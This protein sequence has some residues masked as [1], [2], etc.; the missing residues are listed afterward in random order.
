MKEERFIVTVTFFAVA[1]VCARAVSRQNTRS[2][3]GFITL[4]LKTAVIR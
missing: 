3:A 2:R 1:L 4:F